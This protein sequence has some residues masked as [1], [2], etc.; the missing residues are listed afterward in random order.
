MEAQFR[1]STPGDRS[2]HRA[3]RGLRALS[4]GSL[5]GGLCRRR[6]ALLKNVAATRILDRA[7]TVIQNRRAIQG[8]TKMH[9]K[10]AIKFALPISNESVLSV[11]TELTDPPP[12]FPPPN[13]SP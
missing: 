8:E 2:A 7:G 13:A 1:R 5:G 3:H 6:P 12:T 10:D 9:M 11:T 4:V